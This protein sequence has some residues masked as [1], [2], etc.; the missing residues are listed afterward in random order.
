VKKYWFKEEPSIGGLLLRV[1][2]DLKSREILKIGIC[3]VIKGFIANL[4]GVYV[5]IEEFGLRSHQRETKS[6]PLIKVM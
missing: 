5:E 6:T 3:I 1:I 4:D 2:W